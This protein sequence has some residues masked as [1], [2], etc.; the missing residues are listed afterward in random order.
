MV[1]S[2]VESGQERGIGAT[3]EILHFTVEQGERDLDLAI[4]CGED[5][6]ALDASAIVCPSFEFM[7]GLD[8]IQPV[9]V[10]KAGA[11]VMLEAEEKARALFNGTSLDKGLKDTP[12]GFI[13]VTGAGSLERAKTIIHVNNLR[14]GEDSQPCDVEAVELCVRDS[15]YAADDANLES[16]AIPPIGVGGLW[17]VAYG[18]VFRNHRGHERL[19]AVGWSFSAR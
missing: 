2:S 18:V 3:S 8:G 1:V 19:S 16:V 14:N 17:N 15:L 6:T 4:V 11:K 12:L 13:V 9:L 7:S 5:I 10:R